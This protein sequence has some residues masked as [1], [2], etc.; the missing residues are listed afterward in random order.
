MSALTEIVIKHH[1]EKINALCES[2][3]TL[4]GNLASLEKPQPP[5]A[6][7]DT[8]PRSEFEA[9]KREVAT[10][11][12]HVQDMTQATLQLR[13]QAIVQ[14]A[15]QAE[16]EKTLRGIDERLGSLLPKLHA[17]LADLEETC[18][19]LNRREA[20]YN[21]L[22]SLV[23]EQGRL[24]EQLR[25][26]A[27]ADPSSFFPVSVSASTVAQLPPE[28]EPEPEPEPKPEPQQ[29]PEPEDDASFDEAEDYMLQQE[30]RAHLAGEAPLLAVEVDPDLDP[31]LR[32][33]RDVLVTGAITVATGADDTKANPAHR[34]A[35]GGGTATVEERA[36]FMQPYS[37]CSAA[38]HAVAR[39]HAENLFNCDQRRHA[40]EKANAAGLQTLLAPGWDKGPLLD[41]VTT[42]HLSTHVTPGL[43]FMPTERDVDSGAPANLF[44]R[45]A[46]LAHHPRRTTWLANKSVVR[47]TGQH[48]W[49]V[50]C[51]MDTPEA[52]TVY[53]IGP[54]LTTD[55]QAWQENSGVMQLVHWIYMAAFKSFQQ[56]R[57]GFEHWQLDSVRS[58][59]PGSFFYRAR[60]LARELNSSPPTA[61]PGA[62]PRILKLAAGS[63]GGAGKAKF[64]GRDESGRVWHLSLSHAPGKALMESMNCL[65]IDLDGKVWHL[66]YGNDAAY[67]TGWPV[68]ATQGILDKLLDMLPRLLSYELEV[69]TVC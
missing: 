6:P 33:P 21:E 4:E 22:Q 62:S 27:Q 44:G 14:D 28:P 40:M 47:S 42:L 58:E 12:E 3:A 24:L 15:A 46:T 56:G 7:A 23:V 26:A 68:A 37:L 13:E 10:L 18:R 17:R 39:S 69:P 25:Q 34:I 65:P 63:K 16:Y 38:Y 20:R 57:D 45:V 54:R 2:V 30:A 60:D 9:C 52:A 19:E 32:T 66:H 48:R 35:V 61:T 53:I 11:K 59:Q 31:D 55:A 50:R 1:E 8:V 49:H 29:A 51:V 36:L 64:E 5:Q 41:C 67:I 43:M